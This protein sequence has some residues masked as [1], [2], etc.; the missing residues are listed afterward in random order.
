MLFQE[1]LLY[2]PIAILERTLESTIINEYDGDLH[3][4]LELVGQGVLR[5]MFYLR[6]KV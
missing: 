1:F 2:P 5:K 4:Y 6:L 3:F